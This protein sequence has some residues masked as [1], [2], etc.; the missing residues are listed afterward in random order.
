MGVG[1][2]EEGRDVHSLGGKVTWAYCE[3]VNLRPFGTC[4]RTAFSPPAAFRSHEP[5]FS[6][7]SLSLT[8][9]M[10]KASLFSL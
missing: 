5:D 3:C 4:D 6:I 7:T 1:V 8:P 10:G 9:Q 2:A